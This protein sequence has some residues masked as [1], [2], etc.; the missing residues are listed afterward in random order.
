MGAAVVVLLAECDTA[1]R[2]PGGTAPRAPHRALE[3]RSQGAPVYAGGDLPV[4]F[5]SQGRE[6][7][8]RKRE[9]DYGGPRPVGVPAGAHRG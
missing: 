4:G 8:T 3:R 9:K 1:R 2:G 7:P 6:P 5:A